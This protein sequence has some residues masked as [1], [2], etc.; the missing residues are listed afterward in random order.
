MNQIKLAMFYKLF[1]AKPV[2]SSSSCVAVDS[3][4]KDEKVKK[5]FPGLL[6]QYL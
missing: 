6:L 4:A 2:V 3:V 1:L 5:S